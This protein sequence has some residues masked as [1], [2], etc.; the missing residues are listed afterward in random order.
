MTK[1]VGYFAISMTR[2][3]PW[4]PFNIPNPSQPFALFGTLLFVVLLT[5]VIPWYF[6]FFPPT[7]ELY[8]VEGHHW[9]STQHRM[10]FISEKRNPCL[11]FDIRKNGLLT[12][13]I[14]TLLLLGISVWLLPETNL[15]KNVP[16]QLLSLQ[17]GLT[18]AGTIVIVFLIERIASRDLGTNI[19]NLFLARSKVIPFVGFLLSAIGVNAAIVHIVDASQPVETTGVIL[20][21]VTSL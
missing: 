10:D 6:K 5:T 3:G 4:G 9:E 20:L 8:P 14:F 1:G 2:L 12:G 17:V 11:S 7:L 13:P 16:S 19:L 18:G 21:S 15:E